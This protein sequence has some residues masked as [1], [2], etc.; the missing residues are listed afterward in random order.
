MLVVKGKIEEYQAVLQV[1]WVAHWLPAPMEGWE[2]VQAL[3]T[4]VMARHGIK[5]L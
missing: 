4:H 5:I 2:S 3:L 1:F